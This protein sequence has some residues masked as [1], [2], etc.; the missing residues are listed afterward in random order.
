MA[1]KLVVDSCCDITDDMK[2]W[3]NLEIVPLTLQIGDYVIRMT[4]ISIRMTS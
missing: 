2:E 4:P 3:E 1:Y